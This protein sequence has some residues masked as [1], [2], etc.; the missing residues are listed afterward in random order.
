MRVQ[1]CNFLSSFI[2]IL[3][4]RFSPF[5][6]FFYILPLLGVTFALPILQSPRLTG[7]RSYP[8]EAD[9]VELCVWSFTHPTHEHPAIF[10][11]SKIEGAERGVRVVATSGSWPPKLCFFFCY[12]PIVISPT[13][14]QPR[15][16]GFSLKKWA[17]DEV[18]KICT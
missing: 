1:R 14:F 18:D 7:G 6:A 12:L 17:G 2:L 10:P 3:G 8:K 11:P 16:Q 9:E 13:R 4:D 15:P 5:R